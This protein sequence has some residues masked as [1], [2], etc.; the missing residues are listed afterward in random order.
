MKTPHLD[1]Y[2]QQGNGIKKAIKSI[3]PHLNIAEEKT[4]EI[5]RTLRLVLTSTTSPV[6]LYMPHLITIRDVIRDK[7]DVILKL[8]EEL[9]CISEEGDKK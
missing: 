3:L 5:G 1:K 7:R 8:L 4:G 6:G 2:N 9:P